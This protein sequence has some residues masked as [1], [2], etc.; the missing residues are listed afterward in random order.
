LGRNKSNFC[1]DLSCCNE[2][3]FTENF[4]LVI[5]LAGKAHEVP[6]RFSEKQEFFDVNVKGTYNLLKGL[7]TTIIPKQFVFVSTVAV[8]G[9]NSGNLINENFPL[10]ATDPYGQS[11]IHAEQLI[12]DWCMKHKVV[13]TILRLPLIVGPNPP[14][15]LGIMI[16]GIKRGYY[17][18]IGGGRAQKSMVL[19][20]DVANQIIKI[21]EIGGVY[22][23]SDGYHPN[24]NELSR[25]IAS[26][27]GVR[28]I[29]NISYF[30]AKVFAIV[31]DVLGKKIPFDSD[32]L[33]KIT[34][35]L[36]F[37]D[38]KARATFGWNPTPVLKGFKI[39]L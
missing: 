34:A 37:D 6:K 36:T 28:R 27:L 15:N 16:R 29:P 13:C 11:K 3:K 1:V 32:K 12:Q 18:N 24:F 19:A 38:S 5:H 31:G 9:V 22:N 26:Q 14:G 33:K 21:A 10:L 39:K 17:F 7:E 25:L 8:Y 23:L 4:K 2:I 20:E 30:L 35:N